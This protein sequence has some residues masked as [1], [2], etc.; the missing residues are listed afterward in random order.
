MMTEEQVLFAF[1][2]HG[3]PFTRNLSLTMNRPERHPANPVLPIG[4]PGMPASPVSRP[5][6]LRNPALSRRLSGRAGMQPERFP[7]MSNCGWS[8]QRRMPG[9]CTRCMCRPGL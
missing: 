6:L 8:F 2:E 7:R 1:D 5:G 3:I 4:G 9:G